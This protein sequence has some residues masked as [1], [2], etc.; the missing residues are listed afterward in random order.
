MEPR[1]IQGYLQQTEHAVRHLYDGIDSCSSIVENAHSHWDIAKIGQPRTPDYMDELRRYLELMDKYIDLR[2]SEGTFAG[3]ILQVAATGIR[4][5]ST[6]RAIPESCKDMGLPKSAFPFCIGKELSG[7][8]TGLIIYA[9][10]NQYAHWESGRCLREVNKKVFAALSLA[11]EDDPF[12]DAA[13]DPGYPTVT[14]LA[15]EIL[16]AALQWTTYER[17]LSEMKALFADG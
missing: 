8:P 12:A 10:R 2:F 16:L 13:F 17:Y 5:F 7:L 9:G 6:N 15:N 14:V 11:Y 4:V 1:T 3:A